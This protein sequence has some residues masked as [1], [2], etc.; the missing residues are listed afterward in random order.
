MQKSANVL[1]QRPTNPCDYCD[2][3]APRESVLKSL[4]HEVIWY[5]CEKSEYTATLKDYLKKLQPKR[6]T[7][8]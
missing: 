4:M 5:I 3:A 6:S 8:S 2:F 7:W 1:K